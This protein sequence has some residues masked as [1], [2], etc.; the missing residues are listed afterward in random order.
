M[1][2]WKLK[3]SFWNY[4]P[5]G[6]SSYQR[7]KE[8]KQ[9]G[10]NLAMSYVYD[11]SKSKKED[12][13]ALLDASKKEGIDVLIYDLRTSFYNLLAKGEEEFKKDVE[14]A[15]EDFGRHPATYGFCL[16]DEP[17]FEQVPF[18]IKT[19]Q[20]VHEIMPDLHHFG[21]LLPYFSNKEEQELLGRNE[22][23]YLSLLNQIYQGGTFTSLS[24]DQYRQCYDEGMNQKE[25]VKHFLYGLRMFQKASKDFGL[26]MYVSLL[27]VRH[28]NYR[29]PTYDDFRWQLAVSLAHGA[30]GFFW[31][32]LEGDE[33]DPAYDYPAIISDSGEHTP[34]YDTLRRA[35]RRFQKE[36]LPLFDALSFLDVTYFGD[37]LSRD[38]R[39]E[40][41]V[42]SSNRESLSLLSR[43]VDEKGNRYALLVNANQRL[44]N[45]YSIEFAGEKKEKW[46]LPG[47]FALFDITNRKEVLL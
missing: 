29:E 36:V 28:W 1:N 20:I 38:Y 32:Y 37:G 46:L 15:Y 6:P 21:N 34:L 11:P 13:I 17:N 23:F 41:I 4:V 19:S 35:E 10:I 45:F 8:W 25:G 33:S 30:R 31:F 9:L 14:S 18:F 12:M 43:F 47:A 7:V 3:F 22:Q 39:D 44:S 2:D 24:F 26:P 42:I 27:A 16:G 40:D 5:L